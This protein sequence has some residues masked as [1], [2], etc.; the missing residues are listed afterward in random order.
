MELECQSCEKRI[1]SD[2]CPSC[3]LILCEYCKVKHTCGGQ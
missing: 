3:G 2:N 1:A